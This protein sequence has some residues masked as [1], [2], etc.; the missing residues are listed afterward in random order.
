MPV[1]NSSQVV[2]ISITGMYPYI[3]GDLKI[4]TQNLIFIQEIRVL[5]HLFNQKFRPILT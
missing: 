5:I 3:Q 4:I 1:V 2:R